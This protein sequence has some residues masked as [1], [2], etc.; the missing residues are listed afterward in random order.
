MYIMEVINSRM[1]W[2]FLMG[3]CVIDKVYK[4]IDYLYDLYFISINV[5]FVIFSFG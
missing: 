3:V 5:F 2:L 1:Y 4:K